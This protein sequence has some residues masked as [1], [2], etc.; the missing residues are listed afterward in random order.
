VFSVILILN[1]YYLCEINILKGLEK[2]YSTNFTGDLY[3]Q[4]N[5]RPGL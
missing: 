5:N 3:V 4:R 2:D 1:I